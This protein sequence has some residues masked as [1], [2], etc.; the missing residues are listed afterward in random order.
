MTRGAA[1]EE[2]G[3][4][5]G[6]INSRGTLMLVDCVVSN[7]RAVKGG[8]IVNYGSLTLSRAPSAATEPRWALASTTPEN[9]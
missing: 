9:W 8:G 1:V 6:G 4:G 5:G 2:D 7:N 3:E